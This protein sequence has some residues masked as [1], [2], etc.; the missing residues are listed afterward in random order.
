MNGAVRVSVVLKQGAW[1]LQKVR[2]TDQV[3]HGEG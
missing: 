1:G 2:A 3:F